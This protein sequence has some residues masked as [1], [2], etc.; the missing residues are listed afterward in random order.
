VTD[1]TPPWA[2]VIEWAQTAGVLALAAALI[3]GGRK[4]QRLDDHDQRITALE[5]DRHDIA[6][7]LSDLNATVRGLDERTQI[8]LELMRESR[9]ELHDLH[10]RKR[11]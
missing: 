4:L 1:G 11:P 8:M 3:L 9:D 7:T 6:K 10:D 2:G 5:T